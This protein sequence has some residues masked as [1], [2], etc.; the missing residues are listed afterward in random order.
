MKKL[1]FISIAL[2][3]LI[4][5][6]TL[7]IR[8]P[9]PSRGYFSLGDVAV[10]FSGLVL[11]NTNK[12]TILLSFFVAAIGSAM[13]D[14]IG[15]FAIFAPLTF[16]AKGLESMFANLSF[17]KSVFIKYIFLFLSALSMVG[18]YFIFEVLMPN[19]GLQLAIQEIIPN[20]VQALGGL[21][22]GILTFNA[23]KKI[24]S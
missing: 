16:F 15:G 8:I 6:I 23:Y 11:A 1:N 17:N 3:V 19:I 22:G 13:A 21:V 24:R 12:K 7:F 5:L 2:V 4:A 14:I 9:L 10:I 18:V 20:V